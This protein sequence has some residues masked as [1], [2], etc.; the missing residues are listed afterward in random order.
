MISGQDIITKR[1]SH[2][3]DEN[4]HD[5]QRDSIT[6]QTHSIVTIYEFIKTLSNNTKLS[7]QTIATVLHSIKKEKFELIAKNENLALKKIEEQLISAIYDTIINKISYDIKEIRT[8]NT[9]LTDK[10]GKVKNSI[11]AGSLGVE[12]Y[13]ITKP[14]IKEKSI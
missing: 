13:K 11:N 4:K 10:D 1:D 6:L 9:S 2:I 3:E 14:S 7:L 5:S 8:S 12:T